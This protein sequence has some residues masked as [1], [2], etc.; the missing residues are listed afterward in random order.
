MK[1]EELIALLHEEFG[2]DSDDVNEDTMLEEIAS[3][4]YEM[5]ELLGCIG[6]ALGC[7]INIEPAEDWNLGNLAEAVTKAEE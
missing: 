6:E 7:E 1:V 3:D 2:L 4:E 5:Q